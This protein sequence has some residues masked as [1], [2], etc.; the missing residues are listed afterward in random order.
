MG[1][2]VRV[3][4]GR[5]GSEAVVTVADSGIGIPADQKEHLFERFFRARN[6]PISGFGGLGLG[7]YICRDIV[8]RHGGRIWVESEVE[9]GS[10]F[11]VALPMQKPAR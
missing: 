10:T 8:Q 6:A 5:R 2:T 4:V 1:G 3:T 11:H 7:L 9:H